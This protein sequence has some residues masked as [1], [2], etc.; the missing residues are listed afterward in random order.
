MLVWLAELDLQLTNVEHVSE[1][2]VRH[3]ILRLNVSCCAPAPPATGGATWLKET[4]CC[5]CRASRRRSP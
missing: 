3:K 5:L 2:H 1:S 4:A